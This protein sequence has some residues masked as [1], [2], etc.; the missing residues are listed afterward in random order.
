MYA[1]VIKPKEK[2]KERKWERDEEQ[3]TTVVSVVLC[4]SG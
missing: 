2:K 1:F 3:E 4:L